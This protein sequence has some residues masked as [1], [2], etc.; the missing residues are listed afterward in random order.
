MI[1]HTL[2]C[3]GFS[4]HWI[5]MI[6]QCISSVSFSMLLNSCPCSGHLLWQFD[7]QDR[8]KLLM[9]KTTSNALPLRGIYADAID[10]F[11]P[12]QIQ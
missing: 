7:M 11:F 3:F 8:L 4:S 5:K 10:F 9:W 6:E 2:K 12:K 1:L